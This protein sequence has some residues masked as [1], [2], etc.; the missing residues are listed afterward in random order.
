VLKVLALCIFLIQCSKKVNQFRLPSIEKS[1]IVIN[2]FYFDY[3]TLG[4]Y[5]DILGKNN[6]SISNS[7][8]QVK[9]YSFYKGI[10]LTLNG[11]KWDTTYF[12]PFNNGVLNTAIVKSDLIGDSI[13]YFLHKKSIWMFNVL[14]YKFKEI[15]NIDSGVKS[16]SGSVFYNYTERFNQSSALLYCESLNKLYFPIYTFNKKEK[17]YL[18]ASYN[19]QTDVLKIENLIRPKVDEEI[20]Q[21]MQDNTMFK[22]KNQTLFIAFSFNKLGLRYDLISNKVDTLNFQSL[23]DTILQEAYTEKNTGIKNFGDRFMKTK[24]YNAYYGFYVYNPFKNHFYKIF[25]KKLDENN[26]KGYKNT[27]AE[28]RLVIQLY[29]SEM[30]LI[31]ELDLPENMNWLNSLLPCNEGVLLLN[32]SNS[33]NYNLPN[34]TL[35]YK[36]FYD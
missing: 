10:E 28:K 18:F 11:S 35:L 5:W 31:N 32:V 27:L 15:K 8:N 14:N 4:S 6:L 7:K 26:V 25:Y 36:I 13:V 24:L 33:G 23:K 19:L 16:P 20:H 2:N 17:E 22:I 3:D 21:I 12:T 1:S 30:K 34:K 9:F 29:D